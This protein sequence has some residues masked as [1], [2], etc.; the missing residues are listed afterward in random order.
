MGAR[1]K[2]GERREAIVRSAI[3]LFAEKGFRGATTRELASALGVTEPV[4]YQHFRAKGDLYR[5]IIEAK[6]VEASA[7]AG[8]LVQLSK[9]ADDRA[10]FSA[11]G[12]LILERYQ[13]DPEMF[14][15]LYFSCLEGHELSELFFER[16]FHDFYR[17]VSG[18]IRRRVRE[19]AFRS[20]NADL[21][22][23]GLIGMLSHHAQASWLF[24]GK[25]RKHAQRKIVDEMVTLFLEG[26]AAR[27]RR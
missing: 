11:L 23:R 21:A 25:L 12:R 24:P 15:L 14:R 20:V 27:R 18:Y 9:G 5:A 16:L 17:L 1:M 22:A 13:N 6:A 8:E 2:S 26:I 4:L 7:Q 19:G 10:F 3:H